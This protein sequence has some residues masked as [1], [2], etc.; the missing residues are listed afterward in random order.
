ML[1][2]HF[3]NE[4]LHHYLENDNKKVAPIVQHL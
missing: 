4:A 1:N 2:G 3:P